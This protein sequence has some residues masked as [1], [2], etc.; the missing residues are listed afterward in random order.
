MQNVGFDIFLQL[1]DKSSR[2]IIFF[3]VIFLKSSR[4]SD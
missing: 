4:V 1:C 3:I 2:D